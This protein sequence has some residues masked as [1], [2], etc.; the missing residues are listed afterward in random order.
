MHSAFVVL[1]LSFVILFFSGGKV[2]RLVEINVSEKL[3]STRCL[4][5]F[6]HYGAVFW[7]L[8]F[9]L[10]VPLYM[11]WGG[12]H[13]PGV[14]W[15]LVVAD[16]WLYVHCW[17]LKVATCLLLARPWPGGCYCLV[18]YYLDKIRR[19]VGAWWVSG[20]VVVY[21]SCLMRWCYRHCLWRLGE[22]VLRP[23]WWMAGVGRSDR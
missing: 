7:W 16:T 4:G 11:W 1:G 8:L 13:T 12:R 10:T 20:G 21:T 9:S 23:A 6:H 22:R 5:W 2:R 3:G 18:L 17:G 14:W 19:M 15:G